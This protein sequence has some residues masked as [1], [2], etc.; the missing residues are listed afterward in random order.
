MLFSNL[1]IQMECVYFI[2]TVSQQKV[3]IQPHKSINVLTSPTAIFSAIDIESRLNNIA[4]SA[5]KFWGIK[6]GKKSQFIIGWN[7]DHL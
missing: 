5:S 4:T 7:F 2:F 1:E 3:Y 6:N